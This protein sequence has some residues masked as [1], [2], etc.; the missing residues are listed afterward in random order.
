[1]QTNKKERE[2]GTPESV[3]EMPVWIIGEGEPQIPSFEETGIRL[4]GHYS[5]ISGKW[6]IKMVVP[7]DV[8]VYIGNENGDETYIHGKNITVYDISEECK[9]S[10]LTDRKHKHDR[11]QDD[12]GK[13]RYY[14]WDE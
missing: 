10:V 13:H 1:M 7:K 8:S 12:T 4:G 6:I 3:P 9:I 2:T 14:S 5:K 11:Y